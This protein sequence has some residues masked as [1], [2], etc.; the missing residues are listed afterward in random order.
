MHIQIE[1]FQGNKPSFNVAISSA[2]GREPFITIK[3][4]RLVS[5]AKGDFVSW[6]A[7]KNESTGRYWQHVWASEAFAAAVLAEA[8]ATMP[9][10]QPRSRAP[11]D[12]SAPPL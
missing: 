5:G 3:S 4:C 7:T 11:V 12:D 10:Q 9:Q 6:P 1:H 8:Q 2:E